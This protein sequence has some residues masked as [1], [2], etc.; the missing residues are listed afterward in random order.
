MKAI[1]AIIEKADDEGYGIYTKDIP[2]LIGSGVTEQEAK[3]D[4]LE[5]LEE[6]AEFYKE[7][8]GAYPDW[9]TEGYTIEYR[10]DFSGFFNAFP[11]INASEFA[12]YL[13]INTSLMRKY[14]NRLAFASEKQKVLIQTKFDDLIKKMSE[15][16]F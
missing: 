4:F 2:G 8:K 12:R 3:N 11:F 15:V 10:Y 14:K 16:R 7:K 6:Q 13:G 5:V 1:I 9:F